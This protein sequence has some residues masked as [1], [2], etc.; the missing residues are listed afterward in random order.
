MEIKLARFNTD[1]S[2]TQGL[3]FIDGCFEC[4]TLE[5]GFNF[6]KVKGKTRIPEGRYEID[7][8]RLLTPLTKSYRNRFDW[9]DYHL[10]IKNVPRYSNIY[11][12]VGNTDDD[13]DGCVLVGDQAINDPNNIKTTILSSVQA[14]KR[15]YSI[16]SD[17]LDDDQDVFIDIVDVDSLY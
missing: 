10:E 12:H 8:L 14:F 6:I 11:I 3:F 17:A 15:I 9:F 13:T 5:D 1:K 7:K 16:I 4:F 2:S